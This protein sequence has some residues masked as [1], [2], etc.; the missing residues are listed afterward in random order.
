MGSLLEPRARVQKLEG[1][2]VGPLPIGKRSQWKEW[3]VGSSR[4]KY[5]AYACGK[6]LSQPYGQEEWRVGTGRW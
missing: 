5:P 6:G 1:G 3:A 2:Q 4:E